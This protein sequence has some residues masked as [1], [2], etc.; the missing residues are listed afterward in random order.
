MGAEEEHHIALIIPTASL[1]DDPARGLD[2]VG[3]ATVTMDS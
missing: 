1:D 3:T 2:L